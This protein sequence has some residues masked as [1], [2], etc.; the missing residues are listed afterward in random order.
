MLGFSYIEFTDII[1]PNQNMG[2]ITLK[3]IFFPEYINNENK[4]ILT[5]MI[6]QNGPRLTDFGA[7][8]NNELKFVNTN[9]FVS[10]L[11]NFLVSDKGNG[12]TV[13]SYRNLAIEFIITRIQSHNSTLIELQALLDKISANNYDN[14]LVALNLIL[15]KKQSVISYLKIRNDENNLRLYNQ[16]FGIYINKMTDINIKYYDENVPFYLDNIQTL[17][18]TD[19]DK[20]AIKIKNTLIGDTMDNGII[21][22]WANKDVTPQNYYFGGYSN[23]FTP[24][25]NNKAVS[26]N[27]EDIFYRLKNGKPVFL[28]GYGAS[29]A[30]KTSALIYFNRQKEDGIAVNVLNKLNNEYDTIKIQYAERYYN[31]EGVIIKGDN[32]LI[33]NTKLNNIN[34]KFNN[35][36]WSLDENYTHINT[37][38]HRHVSNKSTEEVFNKGASLG[39]I[40][41]HIIDTD[42]NV[43]AT[44]NNPNSSR[45]HTLLCVY[46][47]NTN[48]N[49]N[50]NTIDEVKKT[51]KT[52]LI[53]GDLAGVE[54]VFV[55]NKKTYTKFSNIRSDK[56]DKKLFYNKNDTMN[57]EY[58]D[59]DDAYI[60]NVGS[61]VFTTVPNLDNEKLV[62]EKPT[63][64]PH[65]YKDAIYFTHK[66]LLG[67]TSGIKQK[68]SN[69][70]NFEKTAVKSSKFIITKLIKNTNIDTR[71]TEARAKLRMIED[72]IEVIRTII[73]RRY[74]SFPDETKYISG[75]HPH[76]V[77]QTKNFIEAFKVSARG[78]FSILK[79]FDT[80]YT[81]VFTKTQK[82]FVHEMTEGEIKWEES[83]FNDNDLKVANVGKS[84]RGVTIIKRLRAMIDDIVNSIKNNKH[85][86]TE[87][88][89]IISEIEHLEAQ[90]ETAKKQTATFLEI[91]KSLQIYELVKKI[92][93]NELTSERLNANYNEKTIQTI[94]KLINKKE[95][96]NVPL[97]DL[98]KHMFINFDYYNEIVS[99]LSAVNTKRE[100][101]IQEIVKTRIN[102]GNYINASLFEMTKSID[103]IMREKNKTALS[104]IPNYIDV[105][106]EK[107]KFKETLYNGPDDKQYEPIVSDN[108]DGNLI[109]IVKEFY[110][111]QLTTKGDDRDNSTNGQIEGSFENE[112]TICVFCVL[113][114]SRRANNPPPVPYL[115][116]NDLKYIFYETTEG[117]YK[118]NN[119]KI[120]TGIKSIMKRLFP[121][122]NYDNYDNYKNY[123][124]KLSELLQTLEPDKEFQTIKLNENFVGNSIYR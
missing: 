44:T 63:S 26:D 27:L 37:H 85:I 41:I 75:N 67:D 120:I 25:R 59:F 119:Q 23:I 52:C 34:F 77:K 32:E 22:S 83:P 114:I 53:I 47:S 58:F 111:R 90:K 54:N 115:D 28:L 56:N 97:V 102:E 71:I 30:G 68:L 109:E 1:I 46:L 124:D 79:T 66:Y 43:N 61:D 14:F 81:D 91:F 84:V 122:D 2:F 36:K 98:L 86:D 21:T 24:E 89:T 95:I 64:D 105:C 57:Y 121:P 96:K 73:A 65:L 3:E 92:F 113:N 38:M 39:E 117:N 45:S 51:K 100:P 99:T 11:K 108:N 116:I 7:T 62:N 70:I 10:I 123:S 88:T 12:I 35:N 48:T 49:T 94:T 17:G 4:D 60:P 82:K 69:I 110:N 55:D 9:T 33:N 6:N 104:P 80:T 118:D 18:M 42:R 74:G 72:T 20:N 31:V 16:R 5:E 87:T 50:T 106:Y 15:K 40:L 13:F 8:F 29:G 101:Y 93:P 107:Y 112:I 76:A 78:Y 19:E 103:K